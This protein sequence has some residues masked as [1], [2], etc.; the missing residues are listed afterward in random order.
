MNCCA[1]PG[2]LIWPTRTVASRRGEP[3]SF[4]LLWINDFAFDYGVTS[5]VLKLKYFAVKQPLHTRTYWFIIYLHYEYTY[6]RE[7]CC[8]IYFFIYIIYTFLYIIIYYNTHISIYV[9]TIN[10]SLCS[11]ALWLS[12]NLL[13]LIIVNIYF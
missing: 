2:P 1:S 12:Y 4:A 10:F 13:Y 3:Q 8:F 9:H 11:L 5:G 7:R 6:G